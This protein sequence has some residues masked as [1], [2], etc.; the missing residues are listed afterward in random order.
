MYLLEQKILS[1]GEV[2]QGNIL[3]IFGFLNH[4]I[5]VPFMK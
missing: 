1:E 5:D 3:K 2:Y 4:R